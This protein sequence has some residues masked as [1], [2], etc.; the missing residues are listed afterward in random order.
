MSKPNK[1][2]TGK[3][4]SIGT[5]AQEIGWSRKMESVLLANSDLTFVIDK[6]G[7][8]KELHYS[9]PSLLYVPADNIIGM[10]VD[11][12]LPGDVAEITMHK[13]GRV[14]ETE[15]K[16]QYVY[17]LGGHTFRSTITKID[18][19]TVVALINNIEEE[20]GLRENLNLTKQNYRKLIENM[21]LGIVICSMIYDDNNKCIDFNVVSVNKEFIIITNETDI[22]GKQLSNVFS[23]IESQ[24]FALCLKAANSG[25]AVSHESYDPWMDKWISMTGYPTGQEEFVMVMTDLGKSVEQRYLIRK[26]EERYSFALKNSKAFVWEWNR[27][28]EMSYFSESL[29]SILG[30]V[31]T[32]LPR[33]FRSVLD[34]LHPDDVGTLKNVFAELH[35]RVNDQF[36]VQLRFRKKNGEYVWLETQGKVA[37]FEANDLPYRIIGS[38]LDITSIKAKEIRLQISETIFKSIFNNSPIGIGLF[39]LAGNLILANEAAIKIFK[40]T[41]NPEAKKLNIFTGNIIPAEYLNQ[42]KNLKPVD[43]SAWFRTEKLLLQGIE[44]TEKKRVFLH[45]R[46]TPYNINL[47]SNN[48][49]RLL[50][51]VTDN[52]YEKQHERELLISKKYHENAMEIARLAFWS[53]FFDEKKLNISSE[54]MHIFELSNSNDIENIEIM[55]RII[56]PDDWEFL[57]QFYNDVVSQSIEKEAEYEFIIVTQSGEKHV[58]SKVAVIYE[59]GNKPIGIFGVLQDIT[60]RKKYE[61]ELKKAKE[62]AEESDRLKTAFLANMSH[63]IRTP[64]NSIV[65]FS[66]LLANDMFDNAERMEFAKRIEFNS[67]QLLKLISDIIDIAK[68]ESGSLTVIW[69]PVYLLELLQNV[70]HANKINCPENVNLIIDFKGIEPDLQVQTDLVKFTQIITNLLSNAFKFTEKGKIEFS[71]AIIKNN[72]RIIISDTGIGIRKEE[73][74]MIF[75]RFYQANHFK[76]GTGLGL[77]ICK[78]LTESMGGKIEVA[79]TLHE[80]SRFTVN[81][82]LKTL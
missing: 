70:Y 29:F 7:V 16:E 13:I 81:L 43:F 49:D 25:K 10:K 11:Q 21:P 35:N 6:N 56:S 17:A 76:T 46:F 22:V 27:Q 50:L 18:D 23:E 61:I 82:P 69:E 75:D 33:T 60:E 39:D 58:F 19:D 71:A 24:W 34:M 55:K 74:D 72:I 26:N 47:E 65:G 79:S 78:T 53:Y 54:F 32:D 38:C 80:G 2:T 4:R 44:I 28:M 45:C 51:Q 66:S 59:K 36:S 37:E 42:V 48:V 77:S 8:F 12:L 68:I 30:Y 57:V 1:K 41:E 9:D 15:K 3:Q 31:K 63:E 5:S 14:I 67:N 52:T 20:I 73:I 64:L 40:I 62:S